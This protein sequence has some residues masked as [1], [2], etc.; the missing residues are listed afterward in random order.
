MEI[1]VILKQRNAPKACVC[2]DVTGTFR[3]CV[4]SD[5]CLCGTEMNVARHRYCGS[6]CGWDEEVRVDQR[7]C[8]SL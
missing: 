1:W 7:D 6:K 4:S 8:K 3:G 2:V 5:C